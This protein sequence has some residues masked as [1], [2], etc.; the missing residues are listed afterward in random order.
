MR[1]DL[2]PQDH[3][4]PGIQPE[5]DRPEVVLFDESN[6]TSVI[7]LV[8]RQCQEAM[9][10]VPQELFMKDQEELKAFFKERQYHP[11]KTD[12]RI[13]IAFWN[14]YHLA[15]AL[16][17]KIVM[18]NVYGGVCTEAYFNQKFLLDKLRVSWM[19]CPPP[20]YMEAMEEAL[21]YGIDQMREILGI[22]VDK[23]SKNAVG[24]AEAKIKIVQMLDARLRG[25]VVQR[26]Q[27]MH[28]HASVPA[29]GGQPGARTPA[30]PSE[31]ALA[32]IE[33]K[34]VALRAESERLSHPGGPL[35][36]QVG[37]I[38]VEHRDIRDV[39]SE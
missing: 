3:Q 22:E 39:E 28:V 20:R 24:M 35:T 23:D 14:E 27:N 30:V 15:H 38:E 5:N 17:R 1:R 18:K 8:P 16:R 13:R 6:P 32:E 21:T 9:L 7:N 34:L 10:T 36:T 31:N 11:T 19:L 37:A 12:N 29:P 26:S 4:P 33:R 25:A 2:V